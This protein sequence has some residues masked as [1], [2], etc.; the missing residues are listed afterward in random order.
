MKKR[1]VLATLLIALLAATLM[2]LGACSQSGGPEQN[3]DSM[4]VQ[5]EPV[6]EEEPIVLKT[7]PFYVLVVGDDSRA[8]TVD[9]HG[10]YADGKGRSDTT[11][12][13][14]VDPKNYKLTLVSVPRD[15]T[16]DLDGSPNKINESY[17]QYGI[18]GLKDEIKKLTGVVPDYYLITNFVDFQKIVNE[19]GGINVNVPVY[20]SMKDIVSGEHVEFDAGEQTLNGAQALIF[21]RD[22]HS[23]DWSG[24]AD[25]FRQTN[26]RYI[27]RTMIQQILA[28][29]KTA[30]EVAGA[31]YQFIDS[32]MSDRELE[33]YVTDFAE[34]AKKVKFESYS[35]PYD[36]GPDPDA[37]MW[38]AYRDEDTWAKVIEA[39]DNDQDASEIVPVQSAL[40]DESAGESAEGGEGAQAQ[41]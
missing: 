2:M 8:G 24:N 10:Q 1:G 23:Y 33:A 34:N 6:Q 7:E 14:R 4:N 37:G 3:R 29:P 25:P 18:D 35:G 36:G 32:D 20:E 41:E 27:L 26:D 30:G 11:M 22:R 9:L 39:V 28:N 15:T 13:V 21:A 40:S 12:L 19:L 5:S 31:L 38:L 16:I 17:H